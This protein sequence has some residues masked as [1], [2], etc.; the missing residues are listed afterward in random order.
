MRLGDLDALKDYA[1]EIYHGNGVELETLMVVPLA[2][3]D[4]AP[5]VEVTKAQS[6]C[7]G[8]ADGLAAQNYEK[9]P[10][11]ERQQ[12]EW[13]SNNTDNSFINRG[14]HCSLC[15]YTVE[16]ST[17]YCPNCG[18]EMRGDNNK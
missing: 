12:G 8:F 3:I 13:L 14:R 6:Y 9:P 17:N 4:N 16:F 11:F 7:M 1:F 10:M 18:A 5:T 15:N 2:E